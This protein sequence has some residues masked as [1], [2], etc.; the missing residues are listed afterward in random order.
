MKK[1]TN[2]YPGN[3][4]ENPSYQIPNPEMSSWNGKDHGSKGEMT[5]KH[6]PWGC[7]FRTE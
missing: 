2:H 5:L 3:W 6:D 4:G 1:W 7:D